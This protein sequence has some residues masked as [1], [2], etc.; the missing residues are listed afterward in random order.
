MPVTIAAAFA[1]RGTWA[2]GRGTAN[3]MGTSQRLRATTIGLTGLA[4]AIAQ[5]SAAIAQP[6][7]ADLLEQA[8]QSATPSPS[9]TRDGSA[10]RGGPADGRHPVPTEAASKSAITKVRDVFKQDFAAAKTPDQQVGLARTLMTEASQTGSPSEKWALFSQAL[11]LSVDAGNLEES[12]RIVGQIN[13]VFDVA[14]DQYWLKT[15]TAL[16]AKPQP[17]NADAI[18]IAAIAEARRL[19]A[20]GQPELAA[21]F[22]VIAQG[23]ARKARN[24]PLTAQCAELA[25]EFR[26]SEKA[27]RE[28]DTLIGKY[29]DDP[30]NPQVCLDLGR[31]YCFVLQDWDRGLPLIAKGR[32]TDLAALAARDLGVR[33]QPNAAV[34]AGDAWLNW[35]QRQKGQPRTSA[36][37]RALELYAEARDALQ[38]LERT[39]VEK[40]IQEAAEL[41]T[42]SGQKTWLA[43][44]PEL[45]KPAALFSKDG[46]YQERPYS[47]AGNACKKS[48]MAMPPGGNTPKTIAYAVP[49]STKRL[50]GNAGVFLP[51]KFQANPNVKPAAAQHFEIRLDGRTIW[52]SSPLTECNMME[53]FDVVV[54]GGQ[55][56]ELITTSES[57]YS[58]F[59]A[60]I[61]PF[62]VK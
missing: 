20:R 31:H 23:V 6:G 61:D 46:T 34:A 19:A 13:T 59:A 15:L 43:D 37:G 11:V 28:L 41:D 62:F 32:D 47:C 16:A 42:P 51:E 10:G 38:G 40:K 3:S 2:A 1:N 48:L 57:G 30:T 8:N 36:A 26:A 33:G 35:A 44:L 9:A 14:Y 49:P 18:G 55:K 53:P 45:R 12:K 4:F 39:R 50:V 21:K 56:V 58:A 27:A 17:G 60:W 22:L 5:I 7:L 29:R 54:A 25:T 24:Q 52:K